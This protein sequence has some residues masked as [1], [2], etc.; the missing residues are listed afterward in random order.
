MLLSNKE[1]AENFAAYFQKLD[2]TAEV[3]SH[4]EGCNGK[5]AILTMSSSDGD[6][7]R[8]FLRETNSGG[9]G[10]ESVGR[11]LG[12]HLDASI[13]YPNSVPVY[14]VFAVD[15]KGA[16]LGELTKI[17]EAITV[18]ELLEGSEGFLAQ[19]RN[20]ETSAEDVKDRAMI[21]ATAMAE[22]HSVK[23]GGSESEKRSHYLYATNSI[24]H[25]GE[26]TPGVRDFSLEKGDEW[27]SSEQ[28]ARL[29]H[30]MILARE[31]MGANPDRL[32][33]IQGDFWAANIFFDEDQKISIIDSRTVW[34]EPGIDAAW[35]IG[36]F[37]MQDMIRTGW[38]NG[39]FTQVA[40]KAIEAYKKQTDDS[41]LENYMHLPYSFQAFAE[42]VFTPGLTE[43]QRLT[44]VS[45]GNGALLASLKGEAF[46][47]TRLN[48]YAQAGWE[49]FSAV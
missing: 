42:A 24:I 38:F 4:G 27:L 5:G 12:R 32:S 20:P 29:T 36:E 11:R 47:V 16:V 21:M 3:N 18:S 28:F 25:E 48:E 43:E 7:R 19:L 34:G 10:N 44:L 13:H 46:D 8:L 35:M 37:C 45:A 33:R 41:E 15:D 14:G 31:A 49:D 1:K 6:K 26:L 2:E 23:H 39:E 22:I 40:L 30:N 9:F 17:H